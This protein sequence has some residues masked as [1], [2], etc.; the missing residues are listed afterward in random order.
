MQI[1]ISKART[2]ETHSVKAVVR[3]A[4]STALPKSSEKK[5]SAVPGHP[6]QASFNYTHT[7]INFHQE[8]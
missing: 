5:P 8:K 6:V 3:G 4:T 2:Q 7:G 1:F